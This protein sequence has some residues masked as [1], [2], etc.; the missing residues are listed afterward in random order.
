MWTNSKKESPGNVLTVLKS[1]VKKSRSLFCQQ[2][3]EKPACQD[4][5][6]YWMSVDTARLKL[7]ASLSAL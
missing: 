7:H 3:C 4:I 5:S 6:Y 1:A 2:K